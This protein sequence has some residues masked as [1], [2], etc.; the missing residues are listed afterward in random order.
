MEYFQI[1]VA[2][3]IV[4]LGWTYGVCACRRAQ[5]QK[6]V[7]FA[8]TQRNRLGWGFADTAFEVSRNGHLQLTGGR[9]SICQ[10]EM[11]AFLPFMEEALQ[12]TLLR[13]PRD[14]PSS[15]VVSDV[16]PVTVGHSCQELLTW[17][18]HSKSF[19]ARVSLDVA[20]RIDHSHGQNHEDMQGLRTGF[21]RVVD[22]VVW[23][24]DEAQLVALVQYVAALG[25]HKAALL[26]YGGGTNV[27]GALGLQKADRRF[28]VAVNLSLLS[29]VLAVDT[30]NLVVEVQAGCTGAAL[31]AHLAATGFC[32]GHEPD[33]N[34]FSTVGGWVATRASG[35]K[36][37]R[38][39]N[40]E[41]LVLSVRVVTPTGCVLDNKTAFP[42]TAT[43]FDLRALVLGSEGML[44][45]VL[46]ARLRIRQA[47][48]AQEYGSVVFPTFELG[49]A[50][51][52]ELTH[53]T[54]TMP[55]SVR[56]VDN[57]QFRFGHVLKPVDRSMVARLKKAYLLRVHGF[58]PLRMV[59]CTMVY[60]G[61]YSHVMDQQLAMYHLMSRFG[62]VDAGAEAGRAGYA[63]TYAIAYIRDFAFSHNIMAESFETT[64]PWSKI[65]AVRA[66]VLA[67]VVAEHTRLCMPGRPFVSCRI[68]QSYV[69]GV[70]LYFY[71]AF[72]YHGDM[73]DPAAMY[74]ALEAK[75]RQTIL[76]HGGSLSH[77][78]GVGHIRRA[79]LS[80]T[81]S[82]TERELAV[83]IQQQ[84]DP[85]GIMACCNGMY[86][87][88]EGHHVK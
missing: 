65:H 10:R 31:D 27:S 37:A 7:S 51:L 79:F 73:V 88:M 41:D 48:E 74:T 36:Q 26:P 72:T 13:Q 47:P 40:I 33:S 6:T 35:M 80:Q 25:P 16:L 24:T 43:S 70:C 61:T 54:D 29:Q 63:L 53:A 49:V 2:C 46:A 30:E 34:E 14:P 83:H 20:D 57:L 1:A 59:V 39:G 78:H 60:E 86:A 17:L 8:N 58:D 84:L 77:H 87:G 5:P 28:I 81:A 69:S 50:F 11:D 64:V 85:I 56:L 21:A 12:I 67:L 9:Y 66:S 32:V 18:Q 22:A 23:P 38:Y 19:T 55:A 76:D 62:G 42:R 82:D 44:G 45:I 3:G 52:Q 4:A 68:S 71:L 15:S 75:C